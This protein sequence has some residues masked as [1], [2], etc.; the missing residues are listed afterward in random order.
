MEQRRLPPV[1]AVLLAAGRTADVWALPGG[2]VLRRYRAGGDVRAE[3]D[4][5]RH[6]HRAGFPVPRV[7][8]ADGADL[9]L[10]RV[11]GPT[12]VEA[13]L[14][15][16][17]G[18]SDGARILVDLHARLHALPARRST[19]PEARILH[20][21]LHPH[22]V[23]LGPAGPVV[24][25]WTDSAEGPAA[26]DRATT[27]LIL[28]ETAVDRVE[29]LAAAAQALLTAYVAAA[30]PLGPLTAAVRRRADGRAPDPDRL[31]EAAAL[32]AETVRGVPRSGG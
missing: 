11:T 9:L 23:L 16:D 6:L 17:A 18:P 2:R 8:R 26:L 32:V 5:M 15:G 29:P 22:N 30:G 31:P 28:A 25:D 19:D 14:A 12:L 21:D 4:V 20:L 10:D 24:I 13:F 7:H 3:A 1:G 27:A